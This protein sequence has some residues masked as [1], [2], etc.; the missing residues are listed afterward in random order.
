MLYSVILPTYNER[1]NLPIIF[2]LIDKMFQE[3][4]L[5]YE[6]EYKPE[7]KQACMRTSAACIFLTI[8]SFSL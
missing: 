8:Y 2:Y 4:K 1:E 6:G 5:D 3:S 7:A